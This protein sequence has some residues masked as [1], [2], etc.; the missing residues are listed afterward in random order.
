MLLVPC[1]Y[2]GDVLENFSDVQ[3]F[4]EHL[5][6]LIK[7][8]ASVLLRE[9]VEMKINNLSSFRHFIIKSIFICYM[10]LNAFLF[11]FLFKN[12][13]NMRKSRIQKIS[14]TLEILENTR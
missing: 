13:K 2:S 7:V 3:N 6:N 14:N 8:P 12:T 10:S 11:K 1:L 4:L 5:H 9:S